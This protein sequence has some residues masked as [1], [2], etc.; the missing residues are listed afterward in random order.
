MGQIQKLHLPKTIKGFAPKPLGLLS[1]D[2]VSLNSRNWYL[3]GYFILFS[4]ISFVHF[5][6][7]ILLRISVVPI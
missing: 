4:C 2:Y 5:F 6:H 1:L 3:S 7:K